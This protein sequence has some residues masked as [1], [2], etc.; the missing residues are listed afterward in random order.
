[1]DPMI[2]CPACHLPQEVTPKP[3]DP[4]GEAYCPN[5][6]A[7]VRW[8]RQ[9]AARPTTVLWIDD[10]RLL[11]GACVPTLERHGYRVLCATD[12]TAGIATAKQER[13]DLILLDVVMP[14]TSG[15]EVC[16]QL[17]ADPHLKETPIILLT[18]LEDPGV[19]TRGQQAGAT[20]TL[21]KP[22]SPEAIVDFLNK[23][24]PRPGG[25]P[26]L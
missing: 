24:L 2:I 18:A 3:S 11:L 19:R 12:G 21:R 1:M 26:R 16:Q 8:G 4:P 17:R 9:V 5:C 10:D 15:L 7:P 14:T 22:S 23:R 6:G 13:P 20:T 25:P